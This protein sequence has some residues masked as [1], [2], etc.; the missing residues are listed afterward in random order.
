MLRR[1]E[2]EIPADLIEH[3]FWIIGDSIVITMHYDEHGRLQGAALPARG[4]LDDHLRT[5]EQAWAAAEPF[6]AWWT[7]HPELRHKQAA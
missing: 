7:R 4:E 6:A 2:H 3:D 5:R 1:G